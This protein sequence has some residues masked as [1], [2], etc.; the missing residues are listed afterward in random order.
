MD[1]LSYVLGVLTGGV[2]G[3]V[4]GIFTKA[5]DGK[6]RGLKRKWFPPR[7]H[8]AESVRVER[9]FDESLRGDDYFW[10]SEGRLREYEGKGYEYFKREG[11]KVYREV[12]LNGGR[13]GN[14]YL[15]K[16]SVPQL[17]S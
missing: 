14:E 6:Y 8:H 3:Y 2:G 15:M 12:H 4:A 17:S 13:S 9:N 10:I 11:Q 7:P 5:G 16:R 1:W